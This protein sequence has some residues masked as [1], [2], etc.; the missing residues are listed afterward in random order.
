LG[1]L[2]TL[3]GLTANVIGAAIVAKYDVIASIRVIE[4]SPSHLWVKK[5]LN[6]VGDCS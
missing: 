3:I 1:R 6:M 2:L 4:E 5:L